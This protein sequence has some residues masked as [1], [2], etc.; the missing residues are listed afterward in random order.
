MIFFI[1]I[2]STITSNPWRSPS[3][4]THIDWKLKIEFLAHFYYKKYE[5]GIEKWQ[6]ATTL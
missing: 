3:Y 1:A 6:G 5:N 2:Q 4:L